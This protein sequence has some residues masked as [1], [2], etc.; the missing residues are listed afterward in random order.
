MPGLWPLN[1]HIIPIIY[2][3][4]Q[5]FDDTLLTF[6]DVPAMLHCCHLLAT[7]LLLHGLV[8]TTRP[9]EQW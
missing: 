3:G 7:V 4:T 2:T 8:T 1:L 5:A 6:G 9:S